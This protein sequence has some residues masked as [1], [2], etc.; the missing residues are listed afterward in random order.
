MNDWDMEAASA[1][2]PASGV[3]LALQESGSPCGDEVE[4]PAHRTKCLFLQAHCMPQAQRLDDEGTRFLCGGKN[5]GKV[6]LI[7]AL[8]EFENGTLFRVRLLGVGGAVRIKDERCLS[9]IQAGVWVTLIRHRSNF[10]G[11]CR[12]SPLALSE[13]RARSAKTATA[14]RCAK[15]EPDCSSCRMCVKSSAMFSSMK[16]HNSGSW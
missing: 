5:G 4:G 11:T 1:T 2:A 14:A 15:P 13:R 12:M 16:L 10:A 3:T 7:Q 9:D 8:E 6:L